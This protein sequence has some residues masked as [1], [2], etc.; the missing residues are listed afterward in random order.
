MDLLVGLYDNVCSGFT[1]PIYPEETGRGYFSGIGVAPQYEKQGL[2]TLLFYRLLQR[3][4]EAGAQYMSLF[5]GVN[6]RAKQ[7]YLGAGFRVVRTF[8]VLRKEL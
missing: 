7:I 6:N 3:E 8:A 1:G 4:K 2:G 5:T